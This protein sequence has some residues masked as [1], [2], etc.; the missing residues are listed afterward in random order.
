MTLKF[1]GWPKVTTAKLLYMIY[2]TD[3][4]LKTVRKE[5]NGKMLSFHFGT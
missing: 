4:K 1:I 3:E 5:M 2:K